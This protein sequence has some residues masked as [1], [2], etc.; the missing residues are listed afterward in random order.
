MKNDNFEVEFSYVWEITRYG[1]I[2][3]VIFAD[4]WEK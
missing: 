3:L 4:A 2:M 1:K